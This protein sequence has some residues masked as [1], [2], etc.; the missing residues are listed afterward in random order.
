MSAEDKIIQDATSGEYK[1]GWSSDIESENAPKGLSEDTV[2]YI[3]AK[4]NEPE[5]LLDYRLKSFKVWQEMKEP[6][7][8]H[9]HHP[10]VDFQDLYY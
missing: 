4:K 10:P 6:K 5:W 9:I 7:W 2:R 8:A 1:Y 3:S